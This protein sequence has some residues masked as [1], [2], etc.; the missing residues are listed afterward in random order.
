MTARGLTCPNRRC[1]KRPGRGGGAPRCDGR[2]EL[3]ALV[4]VAIPCVRIGQRWP[5]FDSS[6][7]S[8][9]RRRGLKLSP[10][11]L[12]AASQEK[13]AD[14]RCSRCGWSLRTLLKGCKSRRR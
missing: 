9:P 5:T 7:P 2:L 14:V 10:A 8:G 11:E 6:A 1:K 12:Q 13:T 4:A 3:V